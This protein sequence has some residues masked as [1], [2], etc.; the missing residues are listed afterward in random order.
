MKRIRRGVNYLKERQEQSIYVV[1][2]DIDVDGGFGD[3]V[4]TKEPVKAFTSQRKAVEYVVAN[5]DPHVY[6]KPYSDLY[7]GGLHIEEIPIESEQ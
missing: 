2:E 4:R 1:F 3:A 6:D 7:E 5:N